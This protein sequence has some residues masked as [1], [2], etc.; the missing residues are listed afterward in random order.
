MGTK[1]KIGHFANV[2]HVKPA[3]NLCQEDLS[4][5]MRRLGVHD[6]MDAETFKGSTFQVCGTCPKNGVNVAVK[7]NSRTMNVWV[8]PRKVEPVMA[9]ATS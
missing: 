2:T 3:S 8:T 6:Q 7:R 5:L 4:S 9:Q 1:N